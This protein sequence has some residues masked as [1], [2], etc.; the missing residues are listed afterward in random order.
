LGRYRVRLL[1]LCFVLGAA[2]GLGSLRRPYGPVESGGPLMPP[3]AAPETAG[4]LR[5]ATLNIHSGRGLDG[6]KNLA[7]TAGVLRGRDV[8]GLNEVRG[9]S[10][11]G[12]LDQAA[13]LGGRLGLAATFGPSERRW[14]VTSFGNGLL[15]R[16][17]ILAWR[18]RPMQAGSRGSYR[19]T[20]FARIQIGGRKVEVLV[21]HPERGE[22]RDA[23]LREIGKLFAALEAPAILLGDFN[24]DASHPELRRILGLPG[25]RHAD[26]AP[27]EKIDH[28]YLKGLSVKA[29][30]AV[31]SR[32]SDHPLVWADVELSR[33][34]A[35][36]GAAGSRYAAAVGES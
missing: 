18:S 22:L 15:S 33:A 10:V 9:P 27:D 36:R 3:A 17:P 8:V 25:V 19:A 24:A 26:A 11:F 2:V 30:G 20:I 6:D 12:G 4:T 1:V 14:Y 32:A 31:R 34:E 16:F 35:S 13:E 5:I 21:V 29:A 7:R 28:I 23:Q